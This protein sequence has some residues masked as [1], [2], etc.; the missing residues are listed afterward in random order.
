MANSDAAKAFLAELTRSCV[1]PKDTYGPSLLRHIWRSH[2]MQLTI[3]AYLVADPESP[4]ERV[5]R[6]ARA[7]LS[8]HMSLQEA[9]RQTGATKGGG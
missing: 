4:T 5:A 8:G 2:S 1:R 3:P 7:W 9:M 6:Y